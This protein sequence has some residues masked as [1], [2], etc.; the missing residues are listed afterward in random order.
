LARV[1]LLRQ[2][3]Y[4]KNEEKGSYRFYLHVAH[5]P[6]IFGASYSALRIANYNNVYYDKDA[7]SFVY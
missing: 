5:N 7:T 6:L 1:G 3:K 4:V 2:R